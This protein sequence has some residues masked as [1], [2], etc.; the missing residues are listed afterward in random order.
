MSD[1]HQLKKALDSLLNQD[2]QQDREKNWL[3]EHA[4]SQD[5]KNL[6]NKL[7]TRDLHVIAAIY[8]LQ[9]TPAKKLPSALKLSQP[10]ISRA[11]SK[12]ANLQL[13]SRYKATQNSKEIIVNLTNMGNQIAKIHAQLE[14][15]IDQKLTATLAKYSSEEINQ[16]TEVLQKLSKV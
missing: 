1:I 15:H 10:T 6:I 5:I 3:L 13:L 11:V 4:D 14:I 2:S 8:Q 16:V 7:S 9:P 12:L